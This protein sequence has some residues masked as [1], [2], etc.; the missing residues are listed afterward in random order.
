M[1]VSAISVAPELSLAHLEPHIHMKFKF[2]K[3][4]FLKTIFSKISCGFFSATKAPA[5]NEPVY[6]NGNGL[7]ERFQC[8]GDPLE[9]HV[10][11]ICRIEYFVKETFKNADG[12]SREKVYKKIQE[13]ANMNFDE[14]KAMK[15][16]LTLGNVRDIEKAIESVAKDEKMQLSPVKK[17]FPK[18]IGSSIDSNSSISIISSDRSSSQSSSENKTT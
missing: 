18:A 17:P 16:S 9:S 13:K 10:R 14:A 2:E 7:L 1:A 11:S 8:K 6:L 4:D 12:S 5:E 3:L 15:K